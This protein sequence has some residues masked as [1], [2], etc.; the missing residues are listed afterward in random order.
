VQRYDRITNPDGTVI[1]IHQEDMAQALGVWPHKKYAADGGPSAVTIAHLL[2]R[3]A[4]QEDVDRFTDAVIGQYLA[5]AP[6]AH[7]KNYSVILAGDRAALAPVYDVAS[8]LPYNPDPNSGL[9]RVAMPIAGHSRFGDVD[10]HDVEKFATAAGTDPDRLVERTRQMAAALPDAITTAA[11]DIPAD[12][13]G[14]LADQLRTG[15]VQHC[16]TLDRAP[17]KRRRTAAP[18]LDAE[19]DPDPIDDTEDTI[20]VVGH[21]RGGHPISQHRRRRPSQSLSS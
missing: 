5:G 2:G 15:I 9:A 12:T 6:D 3:R 18:A 20:P 8:V 21:S 14:P 17:T 13:L 7:A 16:A 10:L 11:A 1:R 4:T 19:P